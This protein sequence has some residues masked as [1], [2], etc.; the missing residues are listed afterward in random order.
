MSDIGLLRPG[1]WSVET[2]VEDFH[3][4]GVVVAGT[5]QAVVW[6]T[7]ATPAHMA[8]VAELAPDLPLT[9]V[10]SH[11]DWDH[12]WG[13]AGLS[14]P[15]LEILAHE[16]CLARFSGDRSSTPS[17]S[18]TPSKP[19]PHP[20]T[21]D[22]LPRTLEEKRAAFP[23]EY[24]QV[25]LIPP[26]RTIRDTVSLDLGG[27][28]LEIHPLPGH[29]PDSLVGFVPEWGVFLAGDAVETPLP[30]LNPGSPV[31]EWA[32]ALEDWARRLEEWDRRPE[33]LAAPLPGGAGGDADPG[34]TPAAP[35]GTRPRDP[36][37]VH[38]P[39]VIP[40]HGPLGGPELLRRNVI[41]LQTL[42]AGEEP[43]LPPDLPP[44]YLQTHKAN[45]TLAR[46]ESDRPSGKPGKGSDPAPGNPGRRNDR[47]P[48]NVGNQGPDGRLE[49]PP[50]R[51]DEPCP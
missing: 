7:L 42:L 38:A 51:K 46:R 20:G 24:D 12:V 13:T 45:R 21:G 48:G 35:I 30:F 15:W 33:R 39:L 14:R 22:S 19:V 26:T 3:V 5:R 6:D 32:V 25:V 43:E 47:A 37:Q 11:G 44:F 31:E 29:T 9:V 28:T 36:I 23:G 41:Y 49:P 40:S 8:G 10:F 50:G 18:G 16:A 17:A 4:R 34:L 2:Q 1:L 27:V